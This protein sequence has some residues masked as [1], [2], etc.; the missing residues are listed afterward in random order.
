MK[1]G[2]TGRSGTTGRTSKTSKKDKISGAKFGAL[3]S[4]GGEGAVGST[5]SMAPASPAGRIDALLSVQEADDATEGKKHARAQVRAEDM[6]D[7]LE[8]LRLGLLTGVI[9]ERHLN[10][11]SRVIE[12]HRENIVDPDLMQ[13]LDEIDLRAQVELAKLSNVVPLR[14]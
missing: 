11:L 2:G 6:L 9:P 3:L 4:G 12:S 14:P 7:Q 10:D 5:P 8:L 13:I 1:V